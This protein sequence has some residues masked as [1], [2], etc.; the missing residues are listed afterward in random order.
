MVNESAQGAAGVMCPGCGGSSVR[1]VEQARSE[2]KAGEKAGEKADWRSGGKPER[3]S[4]ADRLAV[5]PGATDSFDSFMHFLEGMV[6][7]GLGVGLAY[8][9]VQQDKPLYTI[10]GVLLAVLL[11]VGTIVVIRGEARERVVVPR[12][13]LRA[14]R[15][16][17]AGYYCS[18]CESVFCPD[19]LQW[20]GT[21]TPEQFKKLM[22]TEAGYA[23]RLAHDDK[24]KEATVPAEALS[25][26]GGPHR[27]V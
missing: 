26:T 21:L 9:G 10:G 12:G 24:A 6:F 14:E 18:G 4:L 2:R 27:H 7:T 20:Q 8:T 23:D 16:W 5:S 22:W 1:T 13:E 15:L 25:R 17:R 3:G 11:F 19:G